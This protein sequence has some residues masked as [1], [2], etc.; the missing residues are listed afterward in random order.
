MV[1]LKIVLETS[2]WDFGGET[3]DYATHGLHKY[4]GRMPP[5][6]PRRFIKIFHNASHVFDPFCG[7]GTTLVEAILAG[8]KATGVD[9]NPLATL[10]SKVKTIPISPCK[11]E[12][13]K[14]EVLEKT[15]ERVEEVRTGGNRFFPPFDPKEV[16]L[17]YWFSRKAIDELSAIST[18]FLEDFPLEKYG[19]EVLRF[20]QL[21][22][23]DTVR[24]VSYQK[25]GEFK[26]YRMKNW[27]E[28]NVDVYR[29]FEETVVRAKNIMK[30]FYQ[31]LDR[32]IH[33]EVIEGNFNKLEITIEPVD[34]VITSPP[35]GDSR[36]TLAYGQ[37]SRYPLLW[38]GYTKDKAYNVDSLSMGGNKEAPDD[39][40]PSKAFSK[41]LLEIKK[42]DSKRAEIVKSYFFDL[43]ASM[44]KIYNILD[45]DGHACFVIGNRTVQGI[46]V[47]THLILIEFGEQVGFEYLTTTQRRISSKILPS[48]NRNVKTINEERI[49]VLH[50]G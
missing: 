3:T 1:P 4:P 36:T 37:F 19:L 24:K 10:I 43:F 27:K 14:S 41:A 40:L 49:V 18:Y 6:I 44:E 46:H 2:D 15:K 5:Q 13:A 34:I 21:C 30:E 29:T 12:L 17:S 23:S 35:Y 8:K 20:F 9:I 50:K 22:F 32:E 31:V 42:K 11:L 45:V 28:H 47:P 48:R 38:L 25:S 16:N 33:V 26:L 7:S 39:L